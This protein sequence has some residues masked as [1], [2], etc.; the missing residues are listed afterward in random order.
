MCADGRIADKSDREAPEARR[1]RKLTATSRAASDTITLMSFQAWLLL[2]LYPLL[3]AAAPL[4]KAAPDQVG[5]SAERLGRVR[6]L[7]Q[8]YIDRGEIAGAVTFLL[9]DAA[10]YVTGHDLAVDGGW[11]AW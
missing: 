11:R 10:S 6:A 8:R 1:I 7:V 2:A 3:A 4:P 9:S 5:V